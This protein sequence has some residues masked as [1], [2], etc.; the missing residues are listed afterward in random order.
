MGWLK[1][2]ARLVAARSVLAGA[3]FVLNLGAALA[4]P[5]SPPPLAVY[6]SLP[7]TEDLALSPNGKLLALVNTIGDKRML[8]V[9]EVDGAP[10]LTVDVGDVKVSALQWAGDD[11]VVVYI[12]L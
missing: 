2:P 6:G 7:K 4:A 1:K 10:L 12:H 9:S 5:P 8:V 3:A 11:H